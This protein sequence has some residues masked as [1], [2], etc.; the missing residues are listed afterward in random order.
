MAPRTITRCSPSYD[1]D[2]YGWAMAQAA[3]IRSGRLSEIDVENIA[4][5]I[6]SVGKSEARALESALRVVV[7]HM[8]KWEAQPAFRS[9]SWAT[10][11]RIHREHFDE[12]LAENPSLKPQLDHLHA[13]AHR[14][15]RVEA[16]NETGLDIESF[17]AEPYSWDD[18]RNAPQPALG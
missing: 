18:I 10:S 3:L 14:S 17:R 4:E 15:A 8:L 5:E 1:D 2:V 11:I 7:L 6:E 9:K 13:R 12:L 16:S